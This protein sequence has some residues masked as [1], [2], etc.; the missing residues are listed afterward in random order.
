VVGSGKAKVTDQIH[1]SHVAESVEVP[2]RLGKVLRVLSH[3]KCSNLT[4]RLTD[5]AEELL[6]ER[7]AGEQARPAAEAK[8]EAGELSRREKCKRGV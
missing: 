5:A 6:L 8:A 7:G 3:G 2:E 1:L 4:H